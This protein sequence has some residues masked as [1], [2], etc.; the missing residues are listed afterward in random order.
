MEN[1]DPVLFL[2]PILAVTMSVVAVVYWRRRAG[3]RPALLALSF[4]AYAG[5]IM[6]K[7]A[8]QVLT[9]SAVTSY[10]GSVS[11]G[12]GLYFGLQTVFLEVGLAYV[13]ASVAAK[14]INLNPTDAVPYGISLAFWE[15]AVLLGALTILNLTV[16]YVLI[17]SGSSA[18]QALYSTLS[19]AQASYFTPPSVLIWPELVGTLERLSSM[20]VH[21]AWGVLCVLAAV[22]RRRRFLAYA[23]PMGLVDALV[24]FAILNGDLFE[25]GIFLLSI[26]FIAV[27]WI[28]MKQVSSEGVPFGQGSLQP[29][30][31]ATP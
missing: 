13:L 18:G 15:N 25:A 14:R 20:L 17:A 29:D 30:G 21:V 6:A 1:I 2:E 19:S 23:L 3:F 10:F 11:V 12:L 9:L 5:A 27:A 4:V 26:G 16:I 22:T 24:P 7:L 28:S 8:I 31:S